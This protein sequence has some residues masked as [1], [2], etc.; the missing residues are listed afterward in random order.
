MNAGEQTRRTTIKRTLLITCGFI[1]VALGVIGAVLPVLPTTPFLL[2]AAACFAQSSERWLQWL[3]NN[4][5]A[6][7]LIRD[8]ETNRCFSLRTKIV[9]ISSMTVVGGLSVWLALEDTLHRLMTGALMLT[10]AIVVLSLPTCPTT[11]TE[12]DTS[13]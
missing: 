13:A 11:D 10:G 3:L 1:A 12:Q 8:W 9:A 5:Y 6:G 2:V 7:P 4:R